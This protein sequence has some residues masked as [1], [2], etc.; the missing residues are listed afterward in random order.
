MQYV[1]FSIVAEVG[2]VVALCTWHHTRRIPVFVPSHETAEELY[3]PRS[4]HTRQTERV[5]VTY[6]V[7]ATYASNLG[8]E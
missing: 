4:Q 6:V 3:I 2:D 8:A 7:P 1:V 5:A